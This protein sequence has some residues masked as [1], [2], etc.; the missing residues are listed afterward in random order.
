MVTPPPKKLNK[1]TAGP[2]HEAHQVQPP[3]RQRRRRHGQEEEPELAVEEEVYGER[4]KRE[5][6]R[7]EREFFPPFSVSSFFFPLFLCVNAEFL[8]VNFYI[9]N[10]K[11]GGG[12]RGVGRSGQEE[13]EEK[14]NRGLSLPLFFSIFLLFGGETLE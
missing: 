13:V 6:R 10:R 8:P 7:R 5:R 2:R 3:L 14:E 1:Q 11:E 4:R 9:S 12:D